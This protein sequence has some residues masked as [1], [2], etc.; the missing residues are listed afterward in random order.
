MFVPDKPS[1]LSLMFAGEARSLPES[2]AP[3]R[4]F[5]R[6]GPLSLNYEIFTVDINNRSKLVCSSM[7]ANFTLL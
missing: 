2:E 5:T 6:V 3:E 4:C 7:S 1:Q